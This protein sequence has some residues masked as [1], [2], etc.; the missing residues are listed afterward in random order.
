MKTM[1]LPLHKAYMM[2]LAAAAAMVAG[3]GVTVWAYDLAQHSACGFAPMLDRVTWVAGAIVSS[4]GLVRL[5][6]CVDTPGKAPLYPALVRLTLGGAFLGT[7]F[8]HTVVGLQSVFE[9]LFCDAGLALGLLAAL[10]YSCR[11]FHPGKD[12]GFEKHGAPLNHAALGIAA[13]AL[14]LVGLLAHATPVLLF[15]GFLAGG[16]LLSFAGLMGLREYSRNPENLALRPQLVRLTCGAAL[17]AMFAAA[18]A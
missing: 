1:S 9:I 16:A 10:D 5:A 4:L 12:A 15:M 8:F 18:S 14:M 7:S 13:L 6:A 3:A 2:P 11:S 17:L